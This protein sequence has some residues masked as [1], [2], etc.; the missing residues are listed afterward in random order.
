MPAPTDLLDITPLTG[1]LGASVSG[2]SARAPF[3]PAVINAIRETL[4]RYK[5]IFLPGLD[6]DPAELVAFGSQFGQLTR[7]HPVMPSLEG[8][9]E[10]LEVDAVRSREN[11]LYKDEYEN[12]TWHADVTFMKTPPL[13]SLLEA[14]VLPAIGGDTAFLD[15]GA[16]YRALSA[17]LQQLLDP[18]TAVHDGRTQFQVFVDH[19]D[20]SFEWDG[21]TYDELTPVN[22]PVVRTHPESGEKL[23]FINPTFTK[24]LNGVTK[25][26]SDALL[27]FLFEHL[28]QQE[29]IVRHRWS[30]GDI[31]FWDNRSTLHIPIKDYGNEARLMHRVTLVGDVPA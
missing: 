27:E 8:Y 16:A 5:V 26:E 18:L 11:P 24:R 7:A 6:L 9:P 20:S 25:A 3:D 31:G 15:L 10:V 30:V 13:G 2:F 29:F 14:K 22:H 4:V 12:D 1:T 21:V 17:P 28:A 23:L 19:G